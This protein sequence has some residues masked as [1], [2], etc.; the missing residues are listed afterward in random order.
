[1][2][3]NI[4]LT[5]GDLLAVIEDGTADVNTTSLTLVGKNYAGYGE[6]FNENFVHLLENFS[7]S[8]QPPS[9]LTGQLWY[10]S[11]NKILKIYDGTTWVNAGGGITLDRSSAVIHYM[12]FVETDSGLPPF[13]VARDKGI[14]IVPS[15][16]YIGIGKS[17][18]ATSKL[19][20]N[21]SNAAA[22]GATTR[23]FRSPIGD[24]VVHV[25]GENSRPA[26]ILM[27][28]YGGPTNLNSSLTFRRGLQDGATFGTQ[29]LESNTILGSITARGYNG[30]SLS[31]DRASINFVVS[32][33]TNWSPNA[34]GTRIEFHCTENFTNITGVKAIL[35][36]NGDFEAKGDIVAYYASDERL[37]HNVR[38]ID[39]ALDKV[40]SLDGVTFNWREIAANKDTDKVDTGIIAQQVAAVLPEAVGQREDGFLGVRYEKLVGLLIEAVKE[41]RSEVSMLKTKQ[42]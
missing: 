23:P 41:L 19:E 20:I 21:G 14:G 3:Y 33:N 40:M 18:A 25:H 29:G 22:V 39:N 36:G 5:N 38:R 7:R 30:Q 12:T 16:G 31:D 9:P 32:E 4:N 37:K 10:D 27:D 42:A 13:K 8:T 34:N 35:Y 15:T 17:T 28:H 1:M 26:K 24:T 2:A 11:T 6:F